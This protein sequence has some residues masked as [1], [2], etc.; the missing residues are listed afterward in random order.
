MHTTFFYFQL[1][2]CCRLPSD[3]DSIALSRHIYMYMYVPQVAVVSCCFVIT[4]HLMFFIWPVSAE[5]YY[6]NALKVGSGTLNFQHQPNVDRLPSKEWI[7]QLVYG[8]VS[9]LHDISTQTSTSNIAT[10][11]FCCA[12]VISVGSRVTDRLRFLRDTI[13]LENWTRHVQ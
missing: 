3:P 12:R 10:Y 13:L 9:L 11:I 1:T 4:E 7:S 2:K 8:M 6:K 5:I